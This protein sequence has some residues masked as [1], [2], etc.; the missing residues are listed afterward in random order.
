MKIFNVVRKNTYY[1]S[2]TLMLIT[3]KLKQ[4]EGVDDVAVMMGTPS[5]RVILAEANLL[6]SEGEG[7]GPNDLIIAFRAPEDIDV[8][9]VCAKIDE[10][11]GK[12]DSGSGKAATIE[13]KSAAK[14]YQDIAESNLALIS[15]PGEYAAIETYRALKNDKNVFLFS[16]NVSLEEE[17]FLKKYAAEKG[18]FVMGPDCGT[19]IING[20]GIGFAN[21]VRTG[22]IGIVAASGTGLQEVTCLL[23]EMGLGISQAIG[24]G[25]RDLKEEIGAVTMLQSLEYLLADPDTKTIVLISKP[26]AKAVTERILSQVAKSTK[27]VVLCFVGYNFDFEPEGVTVAA[28]LEEA[29]IAA[30]RISGGNTDIFSE[31]AILEQWCSDS[32]NKLSDKQKYV[33]ALYAGGTLCYETMLILGKELGPI[34]S[35]IPLD[36]SL[37][38]KDALI[39]GHHSAIDLGDDEF[40]KGRPHPMIDGTLRL[41][42]IKKAA[43]DVETAVLLLDVVIGFGAEADPAGDLVPVIEAVKA[44]AKEQGNELAVIAYVCGT[45]EDEQNKRSQ[46]DKLTKAGVFVAKTNAEAARLTAMLV[47]GQEV[48]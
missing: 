12:K 1:D 4:T 42:Y 37:V 44:A 35:N 7:A 27:P 10:E 33:R 16:D 36:K 32:Q 29:A 14:A 24:T 20:T 9:L 38:I 25:G 22:D 43:A 23:H 39:A 30:A 47:K 15:V 6:G 46:T 21:K 34:Y 11:M 40:T 41:E 2:V 26:P 45:D 8:T 48:K 17:S 18:L 3:K 19:A 28:T 5:N 13:F 31:K